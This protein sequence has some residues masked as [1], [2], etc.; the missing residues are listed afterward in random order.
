MVPP[1]VPSAKPLPLPESSCNAKDVTVERPPMIAARTFAGALCGALVGGAGSVISHRHSFLAGAV[2]FGIV[3]GAITFGYS[4]RRPAGT[5]NDHSHVAPSKSA[6]HA[7]WRAGG[8]VGVFSSVLLVGW[9][10]L[11]SVPNKSTL[12]A[13][14]LLVGLGLFA[15]VG[16]YNTIRSRSNGGPDNP[17]GRTGPPAP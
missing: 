16:T 11:S 17:S 12:L 7:P 4:L 10:Y 2:L 3:G 6:A 8:L 13:F 15:L 1:L 14:S 9:T 5:D